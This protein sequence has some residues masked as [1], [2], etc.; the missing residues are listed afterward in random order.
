MCAGYPRHTAQT[1]LNVVLVVVLTVLPFTLREV[2]TATL[3]V[4]FFDVVTSDFL[5]PDIRHGP[6]VL[7]V[8]V[9]AGIFIT[10]VIVYDFD[11]LRAFVVDAGDV[12]VGVDELVPLPDNVISA[13]VDIF[14]PDS[15]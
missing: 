12:V 6:E 2:V 9:P 1:T 3:H 7:K 4:P 11:L 14:D 15:A 13:A 10:L 5:L 8:R